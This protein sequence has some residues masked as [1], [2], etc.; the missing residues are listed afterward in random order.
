MEKYSIAQNFDQHFQIKFADSVSLKE[1]VY[2]IRHSVYAEELGWE[3]VTKEGFES[4]EYDE[5]A[6]H[7]LIEHRRTG[8][9]A[10]CVRLIV[11]PSEATDFQL[12]FEK[13]CL[14]SLHSNIIDI[15]SMSRTK[16]GEISRL[17]VLASF[18]RRK[19][20]KNTPY[21][22]DDGE[23]K[24]LFS[25]EEKRNFPNIALGLFLAVV[26]LYDLSGHEAM[27]VMMD[28]RLSQ[29][30]IRFGLHFV[31][32]GDEVDYHGRR[33]LFYLNRSGFFSQLP[34]ELLDLYLL[35]RDGIS[36]QFNTR[37]LAT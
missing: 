30:L 36:S 10:G 37:L 5:F 9:F 8:V 25:G 24:D 34:A 29:R 3:P 28:P 1:Q 19:N 33:A 17:A 15:N 11:P 21:T 27:F 7:C 22:L 2:K 18:R 4:D 6:Y 23:R 31:Q 20:E 32:C 13:Y 12:P 26:A 16:L 14:P 35:I